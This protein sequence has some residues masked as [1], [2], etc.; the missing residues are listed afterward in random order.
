MDKI[1]SL[2]GWKTRIQLNENSRNVER[3]LKLHRKSSSSRARYRG[4]FPIEKNVYSFGQKH[5]EFH[6]NLDFHLTVH[7]VGI[8]PKEHFTPTL[9]PERKTIEPRRVSE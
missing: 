4:P 6:S 7:Y 3:K 8:L 2:V 1:H 9:V 5:P